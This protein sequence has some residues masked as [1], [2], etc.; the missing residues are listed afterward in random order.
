VFTRNYSSTC[1]F[2]VFHIHVEVLQYSYACLE[3]FSNPMSQSSTHW[4]LKVTKKRVCGLF[5][6][7]DCA[8]CCGKNV[9]WNKIYIINSVCKPFARKFKIF[10]FFSYKC[11]Y[12]CFIRTSPL[13]PY[14]VHV[15]APSHVMERVP[16]GTPTQK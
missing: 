1:S 14:N 15:G 13:K 4:T 5:T 16:Y 3:L 8:P 2:I 11:K 9:L 7:C 6:F 12:T 10:F